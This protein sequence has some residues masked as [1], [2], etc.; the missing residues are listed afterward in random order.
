MDHETVDQTLHALY[1]KQAIEDTAQY[2][3]GKRK[4]RPWLV[5][6]LDQQV[7]LNTP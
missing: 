2:I 1:N 7:N 5:S 3:G 4:A 6:K